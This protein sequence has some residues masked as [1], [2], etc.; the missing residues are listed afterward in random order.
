M[1]ASNK[2][3]LLLLGAGIFL[4]ASV[5][6]YYLYN[7]GPIDVKNAS[8]KKITA[9]ALYTAY[10]SDSITAQQY[11]NG[12]VVEVQG[13]IKE[14]TRNQKNEPVVLLLTKEED[15]FVNCTIEE[16]DLASLV[17]GETVSLKG[18]CNGLGQAEPD[19]GIKADLYLTRVYVKR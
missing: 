3:G 5:F 1:K 12:K 6:A 9:E 18:I 19:L 14:V 7:K 10:L 13:S 11:Y 16:K 17:K 8:A 4:A 15:A 2:K